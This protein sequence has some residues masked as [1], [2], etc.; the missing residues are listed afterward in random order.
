MTNTFYWYDYETFGTDP[1][2]DWPAQFAGIRTDEDFNEIGKPLELFVRLPDDQVPNPEACLVTGLTPQTVNALGICEADFIDTINKV[3]CQPNTCVLG[4]NT[5]RFDDEVTRYSLYR[6]FMN[7]YA[8]EWKNGCSRWDLID[9]VRLCAALRPEGINWP[10][11]EDGAVSFKLEALTEANGINHVA[12]HDAVSDVRATIALARLLR[13]KQGKLFNY[14]LANRKKQQVI[15]LLDVSAR[16][17]VVHISGRYSST[18][19][20]L[21]IVVPIMPHPV[22]KNGVVVYDLS[23]DPAPFM[24]LSVDEIRHQLFTSNEQLVADGVSRIPIKTVHIN[25]TPVVIPWSVLS[26]ED[27]KQRLGVD[28]SQCERHHQILFS[29]EQLF[30]SFVETIKTV[31]SESPYKAHTDPDHML[32]SGGFFNQD[33][34]K[35]I[36]QVRRSSPE[37]LKDLRLPFSDARLDEMLFRYR[38]RNWPETLEADEKSKWQEFRCKR[39]LDEQGGGSLTLDQFFEKINTLFC[40]VDE[41]K[42]SILAE[43]EAYG[44]QLQSGL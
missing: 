3:F 34:E 12:A 20:C 40:E 10:K 32:Y 29:D 21:G 39:L 19:H 1:A 26:N 44:R 37:Q 17:P 42:Q 28:Q 16:K 11:R 25:K 27:D 18:R 41:K 4:Y 8:R 6:N 5:M 35:H 22:N 7:P 38:A 15:K 13:E 2:R 14:T 36:Q 33:D 9:V 30:Q 23:V 31:L 24:E 43:L